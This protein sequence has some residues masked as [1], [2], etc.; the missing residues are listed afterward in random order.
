VIV[1]QMRL[2]VRT[3]AR[4]CSPQRSIASNRRSGWPRVGCLRVLS[5]VSVVILAVSVQERNIALPQ[6]TC[7]RQHRHLR[8]PVASCLL[9]C[10]RK[11][12]GQNP[13]VCPA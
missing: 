6:C 7:E 8:S 5:V 12:N 1:R 11:G 9:T 10:Q 13:G 2:S 3:A 4:V